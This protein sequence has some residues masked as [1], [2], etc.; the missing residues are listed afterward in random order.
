[1]LFSEMMH[2]TTDSR[3]D[4][5]AAEGCLLA[6]R[7]APAC[8][9]AARRAAP[10]AVVQPA[11]PRAPAAFG[12]QYSVWN[13]EGLPAIGSTIRSTTSPAVQHSASCCA[14]VG[15][16]PTVLPQERTHW[17]RSQCSTPVNV[18][19]RLRCHVP[20]ELRTGPPPYWPKQQVAAAPAAPAAALQ[21]SM[22]AV[23]FMS[24]CCICVRGVWVLL[25]AQPRNVPSTPAA[26][27]HWLRVH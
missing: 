20:M 6:W 25:A 8:C 3:L 13:L 4:G 18:V 19:R 1:M 24:A 15:C 23:R 9:R 27:R 26:A 16:S 17:A 21:L 22:R 14:S 5:S 12:R 7:R 2:R 11:L 10:D